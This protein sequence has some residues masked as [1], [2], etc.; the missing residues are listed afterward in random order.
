M[1]RKI[2]I[3]TFAA[4]V[5][6]SCASEGKES[7]SY[8]QPV[9]NI[10]Y[11]LNYEDE[12]AFLASWLPQEKNLFIES[13]LYSEG[14]LTDIF[15]EKDHAS[16]LN[17]TISGD[18]ELD[19]GDL[20]ELEKDFKDRTGIHIEFDKG[21]KLT[22]EFSVLDKQVLTQTREYTVVRYENIWYIYGEVDS[23]PLDFSP[24]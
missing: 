23:S 18:E 6:T 21:R 11:A 8:E 9:N 13:G 5:L 15:S 20:D 2:L 17:I 16:R 19:G 22:A 12:E 3:F 24:A 4:A 10:R 14:F 7:L 1:R